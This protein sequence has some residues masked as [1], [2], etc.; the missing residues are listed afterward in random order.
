[1]KTV[2]EIVHSERITTSPVF[3]GNLAYFEDFANRVWEADLGRL[4][5]IR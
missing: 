5:K 3:D 1:M 2:F 4:T